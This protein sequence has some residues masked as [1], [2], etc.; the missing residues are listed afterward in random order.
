MAKLGGWASMGLWLD[1]F[2]HASRFRCGHAP[3]LLAYGASP[4]AS[5]CIILAAKSRAVLMGRATVSLD[6]VRS[7]AVA[8]VAHRV[9]PSFRAEAEGMDGRKLVER[10]LAE[11]PA[12]VTA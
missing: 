12:S 7:L 10:L 8:T 5:Q 2:A 3:T 4:R 1:Q 6:D 9:V 11:I